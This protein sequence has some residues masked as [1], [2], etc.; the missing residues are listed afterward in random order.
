MLGKGRLVHSGS[1]TQVI[2]LYLGKIQESFCYDYDLSNMPRFGNFGKKLLLQRLRLNCGSG[3]WHG[4]PLNAEIDFQCLEDVEGVSF[5]LG[6]CNRDGVRILSMDSDVPGERVR[7]KRGQQGTVSFS[8]PAV[9]LEPDDYTLDI[10]SRS[11]D[12]FGLDYLSQFGNFLVLPSS[13]TPSVIA[14]RESGR[15][16][17]RL[18]TFWNFDFSEMLCL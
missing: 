5:G 12:N 4:E 11:G 15:G 9:P 16:G 6:I 8:I 17:V 3:V 7:L 1:T 14:M 13:A 2:D 18:P 10:G